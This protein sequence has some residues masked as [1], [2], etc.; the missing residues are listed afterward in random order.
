MKLI[1]LITFVSSSEPLFTGDKPVPSLSTPVRS[2][3]HLHR[4]CTF[5][6]L[7][8]TKTNITKI[9]NIA[10][11]SL[12]GNCYNSYIHSNGRRVFSESPCKQV[13][14]GKIL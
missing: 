6:G 13:I 9:I 11:I 8:A 1:S 10:Q 5:F 12:L 2:M 3:H 7:F 4:N 14:S